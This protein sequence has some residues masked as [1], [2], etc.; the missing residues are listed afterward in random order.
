MKRLYLYICIL[1]VAIAPLIHAAEADS[2]PS[3]LVQT[4]AIAERSVAETVQAFGS[5]EPGPRQ[6]REIV[7][8]RTSEVTLN[9]VA[10]ARVKRGEAL[11]T[12]AATPE[13]AVLYAQAKSQAEYARSALKRTQSLFKEKLAT[14]DQLAAAQKALAD[15]E[16]NLAAQQKMGGGRVTVMRAPSDSVVTAVNVASGARVAANTSVLTLAEQGGLYARLGVTPAQAPALEVGM[17]VTLHSAFNSQ[18]DLQTTIKQVGGQVSPASGL[19][20]VLAPVTGKSAGTFLP[21][22]QV[23]AEITV[24]AVHSLAVPRSAVLRDVQGAYIFIVKHH[25]AHRVNVKTGID[26]GAWI[27]VSGALHAG[28]QVVTLGNYELTDGMAVREQ[29]P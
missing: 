25:V 9:V 26:D 19:V 16:A 4:T 6:L 8:P 23:T 29:A 10:G 21:G 2:K 1:A 20:D 12:L 14:R 11:V 24:K 7:A 13:S 3:V 18:S 28:D 27:A 22:T 15:A 5:I 17:P